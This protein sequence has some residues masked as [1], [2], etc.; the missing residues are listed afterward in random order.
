MNA[1]AVAIIIF[2]IIRVYQN[3]CRKSR[4]N[5]IM[6]A[7]II[8]LVYSPYYKSFKIGLTNLSNKRYAQHR[9]K[10][11]II[12]K[13]WYFEDRKLARCV[14]QRAIKLFKTRLPGTNLRKEDMPQ[15]GYTETF[16]ATKISSKRVIKIINTIIKDMKECDYSQI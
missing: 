10:G 3:I 15:D 12:I 5:N 2:I 13:Y 14:E 6:E 16:D 9:T 7:A 1:T 4:Y 8:Y 11:W